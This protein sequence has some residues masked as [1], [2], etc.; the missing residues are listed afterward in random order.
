MS[1]GSGT[2]TKITQAPAA[3]ALSTQ[4][5]TDLDVFFNTGDFAVAATLTHDG[6]PTTINVIFTDAFRVMNAATGGYETSDPQA[7][8]KASDVS[9]AIHG[10]TLTVNNILYKIIGIQPSEDGLV[11]TLVLSKD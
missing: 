2:G 9:N 6:A 5:T 3:G 7:D 4:F 10:D 8:C 1:G 11:V